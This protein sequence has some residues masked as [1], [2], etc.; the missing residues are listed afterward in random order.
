MSIFASLKRK[1]PKR[2]EETKNNSEVLL[3]LLYSCEK[4]I[5]EIQVEVNNHQVLWL[6]MCY[7]VLK[8]IAIAG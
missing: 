7:C 8:I 3:Y 5:V 6:K 1:P 4:V 2:L